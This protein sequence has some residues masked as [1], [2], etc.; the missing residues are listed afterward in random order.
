VP[1]IFP[2]TQ[3]LVVF[4]VLLI[5]ILIVPQISKVFRIPAVVGL[6]LA[7]A[8]FGPFGLNLIARGE[9]VQLLGQIGIIFIM[10]LAGLEIDLHQLIRNRR[11]TLIFGFFTF[12]IPLVM[13]IAGSLMLE[14]SLVTSV[15]LASMFSSHTLLTYPQVSKLG[16]TKDS[17]V[18]VTIGGT[19]I[20]N[21]LAMLILAVIASFSQNTS[22][23][24]G[25]L[26]LLGK[27][28]L[29]FILLFFLLP[30]IARWSLRRLSEEPDIQFLL[31]FTLMFLAAGF[32]LPAGLEPVIGAFF[33]GLLLNR[34][35]PN[36]SM[37]M[38][39]VQFIGNGIFVPLFLLDV[40]FLVDLHQFLIDPRAW[41]FGFFMVTVGILSKWPPVWI[42][43]IIS[44]FTWPQAF[45]M[46]GMSVNQ[47]AGTLAAVIV[48]YRLGFF[49]SAIVSATILMILVTCFLGAVV[50]THSARYLS[51]VGKK[52]ILDRSFRVQ[53]I[54]VSLARPESVPQLLNLTEAILPSDHPAQIFPTVVVRD[55]ENNEDQ[56]LSAE[57]LLGQATQYFQHT[58]F[59]LTPVTGLDPDVGH[60]LIR[61]SRAR[62]ADTIVLGWNPNYGL[63]RY[64][65]G[66]VLDKIVENAQLRLAIL[67]T[68]TKPLEF[69]RLH[70]LF[71]LYSESHMDLS[72]A[73]CLVDE[74]IIKHNPTLI[75]YGHPKTREAL[76][77][78]WKKIPKG[79]A[80]VWYTVDSNAK[81]GKCIP[82]N[83]YS[84]S[85]FVILI[86]ARS[87]Q[88]PWTPSLSRLPQELA[89]TYKENP[90]LV[91]YPNYS[92]YNQ[93]ETGD[94]PELADRHI[95]FG[96]GGTLKSTLS[97]LLKVDFSKKLAE[98]LATQLL[99]LHENTPIDL[100][101]E[102]HLIHLH[103][104]LVH[105]FWVGHI[106]KNTE[107]WSIL[108]T[109]LAETHEN[110][111]KVLSQLVRKVRARSHPFGP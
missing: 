99:E 30:V 38:N 79:N 61:V 19:I 31:I 105:D 67:K 85:D 26:L 41:V 5:F 92:V 47:A 15:L 18:T 77:I 49:D 102:H 44:K 23:D 97:D 90:L 11:T 50:T 107:W 48:G 94:T 68:S 17:A 109:P 82:S 16:L 13:G 53:R 76:E 81:L 65:F 37:L 106:Q 60:G 70:L 7:G 86:G 104:E 91:I 54:M 84:P 63:G 83:L 71:P 2:L 24:G 62:L 69:R 46:Y 22:G 103:T 111:L 43:K 27:L 25:A 1:D 40:G 73:L 101:P 96:W 45:L 42:T 56:L 66:T 58:S 34:Y 89:G 57:T 72:G 28:I 52:A 8:V 9:T 78:F 35:V 29:Y 32:A 33:A 3:P 51:R 108:L 93:G 87:S 21:L 98:D 64:I 39:R 88:A 4:M 20:T 80:F 36:T 75:L 12:S 10:F 110:H 95:K 14:L 100:K 74:I 59:S 55:E 6:I